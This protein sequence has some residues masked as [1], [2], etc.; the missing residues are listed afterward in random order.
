[1]EYSLKN[2][3]RNDATEVIIS[4]ESLKKLSQIVPSYTKAVIITD[5]N[6]SKYCL[7]DVKKNL[8]QNVE[9]I[10]LPIGE[11]A[12][13]LGRVEDILSGLQK[14]GLDRKSLVIGL[15]GGV[16]N[17][18]A[19]F[20]SSSYMRGIDWIMLPTTLTAQ[21]DAS[22]GGKTGVNLGGFKNM[23]GS[24]WPPKAVLINPEFLKTLPLRHLKNGLA[25]IIKM[26]FIYDKN[27]LD[28][29]EKIDPNTIIGQDLEGAMELSAK[30]KIEIVNNDMYETGARKLLNF[31]HTVG[32]AVETISLDSSEPL[33]HGEVIS[34]GMVA[35]ARLA[36]L[37]RVCEEGLIKKLT[38]A[39]QKFGL[40]TS[41]EVNSEKI[42]EII[43]SDKKNVGENIN[44]TLP[45]EIG[46]G[47]Y[48]HQASPENVMRA[49]S[50][51]NKPR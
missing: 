51:I 11:N 18:I 8:P 17:D 10:V 9:V 38:S 25:E 2:Q 44:W 39:L 47:I 50:F 28:L 19:G 35:E 34:I 15:G 27:I 7:G 14:L 26:G 23:V 37:E 43:S 41:Y 21:A 45:A 6:A 49:L 48:N 33:L 24:F 1:M 46:K 32:H 3:S 12:K 42:L 40:P 29:V 22:I 31:G 30:A 13:N 20:V 36:E 16:V 5:E 4:S